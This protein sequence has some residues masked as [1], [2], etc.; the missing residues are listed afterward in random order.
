M[1]L[2]LGLRPT[3]GNEKRLGPAST[4][5]GTV[6]FSLSSREPVTFSIF[7]RFAHLARCFQPPPQSRHPERSAS[8]I[9]RIPEGLLR[10]VEGSRRCLLAE[11]LFGAFRPQTIRKIKKV[12]T[13][14][15][16]ASRI[17][18]LTE[19]LQRVIEGPRE[20]LLADALHSFPATK[21]MREIKKSQPPTGAKRS[22]GICGSADLSWK[23]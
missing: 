10:G 19:G 22:G 11:M 18:R 12:T 9:Y 20:C 5:Y 17:Y 8:Q 4:P 13:F 21:T 14:E 16:S 3:Q 15:R 1:G 23:R 2:R 6:T 7:P